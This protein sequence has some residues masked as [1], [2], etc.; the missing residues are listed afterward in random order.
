[1]SLREQYKLSIKC[2]KC[3]KKHRVS[4]K[5]IAE[6]GKIHCDCGTNIIIENVQDFK[7]LGEKF[8]ELERKAKEFGAIIRIEKAEG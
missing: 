4:V 7:Q 1:M 3:D 2:P 5:K 8:D 6:I